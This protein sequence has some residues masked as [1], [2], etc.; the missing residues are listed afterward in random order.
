MHTFIPCLII[1]IFNLALI[2]RIIQHKRRIQQQRMVIQLFSIACLYMIMISPSA[3]IS[4]IQATLSKTFAKP[5]YTLYIAYLYYFLTLFLPFLCLGSVN[6]LQKKLNTVY[7]T[8]GCH[9]LV[10]TSRVQHQ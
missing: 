6:D 2:I 8:I 10:R 3:I 4:F 1:V 5:E 7:Q 9:C